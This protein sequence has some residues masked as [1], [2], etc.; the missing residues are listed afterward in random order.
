MGIYSLS[1]NMH[2][3]T[4]IHNSFVTRNC[5]ELKDLI[6]SLM[7]KSPIHLNHVRESPRQNS[8]L[9]LSHSAHISL[10]HSAYTMK[11]L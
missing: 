8:K 2:L 10:K 7:T 11:E 4:R 6:I 9:P 1:R 5:P 3:T